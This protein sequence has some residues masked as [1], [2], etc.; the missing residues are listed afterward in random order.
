MTR[1]ANGDGTSRES[2]LREALDGGG[3]ADAVVPALHGDPGNGQVRRG[4]DGLARAHQEPMRSEAAPRT[5]RFAQPQL[6]AKVEAH[7]SGER[8]G[9]GGSERS[10]DQ[11]RT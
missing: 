11:G 3:R 8:L 7:A 9:L 6:G 10:V 5:Q 1:A 2:R 4:L